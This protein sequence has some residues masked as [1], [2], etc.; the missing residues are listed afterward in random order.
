MLSNYAFKFNLRRYNVV[1]EEE[2]PCKPPPPAPPPPPSPPSR[3]AAAEASSSRRRR[4]LLTKSQ[5]G[6]P[7]EWSSG[8][9]GAHGARGAQS[10]ADANDDNA[11]ANAEVDTDGTSKSQAARLGGEVDTYGIKKECEAKQR[12]IGFNVSSSGCVTFLLS[13]E[14]LHRCRKASVGLDN[15]AFKPEEAFWDGDIVGRG[16]HRSLFSST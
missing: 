1:E 2:G 13:T 11:R 6:Y 10:N 15:G 16:L 8:P 5:S 3:T 7:T 12:C 14:K 4:N 9:W